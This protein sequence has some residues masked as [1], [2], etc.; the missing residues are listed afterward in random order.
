M[1]YQKKEVPK[2]WE[3][4]TS[5]AAEDEF[6]EAEKSTFKIRNDIEKIKKSKF[7]EK[8][9]SE[10]E[11][12]YNSE[13][14]MKCQSGGFSGPDKIELNSGSD[15]GILTEEE[16]LLLALYSQDPE[17]KVEEKSAPST[18]VWFENEKTKEKSE[19]RLTSE[20]SS[21]ARSTSPSLFMNSFNPHYTQEPLKESHEIGSQDPFENCLKIGEEIC[22]SEKKGDR[23]KT[24]EKKQS[25]KRYSQVKITDLF[26]KK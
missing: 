22:D 10:L 26:L 11:M 16:E 23:P 15:N 5:N 24:E 20:D 12:D 14:K 1:F 21:N 6:L 25:G 17:E 3:L 18:S 8:R 7:L 9:L 13:K 19:N 2:N 4:E